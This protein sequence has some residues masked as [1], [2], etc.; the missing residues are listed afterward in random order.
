MWGWVFLYYCGSVEVYVIVD[1]CSVV[2][3]FF[4]GGWFMNSFLVVEL[5]MLKVV[6][7][8]GSVFWLWLSCRCFSVVIIFW[9]FVSEVFFVLVWNLWWC[10]NYIEIIVVNR[11]NIIF[12]MNM[13][14]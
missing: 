9:W 5:E 14:M 12:S 11:L 13:M 6:I 8:V 7:W 3:C 4:S 1:V 2:M 10:E